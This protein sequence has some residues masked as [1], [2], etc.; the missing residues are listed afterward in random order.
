MRHHNTRS[1]F[2]ALGRAGSAYHDIID[3]DITYRQ[4]I[5]L[6]TEYDRSRLLAIEWGKIRPEAQVSGI[7]VVE[8]IFCSKGD[9]DDS[10][11]LV[12]RGQKGCGVSDPFRPWSGE[13][14]AATL[15]IQESLTSQSG[16]VRDSEPQGQR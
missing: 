7:H 10:T 16:A 15:H 4:D 12:K 2:A 14:R 9:V 1:N 8:R 13:K 6:L 11:T 5:A 3:V